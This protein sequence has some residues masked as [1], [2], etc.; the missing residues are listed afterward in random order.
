[1]TYTRHGWLKQ[2]NMFGKI[3]MPPACP[4]A[5]CGGMQLGLLG[6]LH[7]DGQF[8]SWVCR[9]RGAGVERLVVMGAHLC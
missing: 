8:L 2:P 7:I 6:R 1:M 4:V 5:F 3:V 9:I